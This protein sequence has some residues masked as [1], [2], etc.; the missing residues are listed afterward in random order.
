MLLPTTTLGPSRQ[1][2][3]FTYIP[4]TTTYNNHWSDETPCSSPIAGSPDEIHPVD[5]ANPLLA[6]RP[7]LPRMSSNFMQRQTTAA[8]NHSASRPR[9]HPVQNVLQVTSDDSADSDDSSSSMDS[10]ASPSEMARCSRCQRTPSLDI[11]TGKSN[12]IQY[13]LNLFYC[14]RCAGIV[15]L[16][17]R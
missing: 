15:G 10:L 3:Y 9:P 13:G 16:I 1:P 11:K 7:A 14:S 2:C 17:N 4:P 8:H 6:H 12:M 5:Q